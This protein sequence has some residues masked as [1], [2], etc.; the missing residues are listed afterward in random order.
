LRRRRSPWDLDP[1]ELVELRNHNVTPRFVRELQEMGFKN[2]DAD[3]LVQLS[4]HRVTK[5]F[6]RE[7]RQEYGEELTLSQLIE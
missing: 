3:D 2:F 6:I 5:R 4:I 7:M 1:D